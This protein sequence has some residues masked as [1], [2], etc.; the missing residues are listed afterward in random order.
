MKEAGCSEL[1]Q[2]IIDGL[3]AKVSRKVDLECH[4]PQKYRQ[5]ECKQTS[6]GSHCIDP[7]CTFCRIR[8]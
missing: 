6:I 3:P 1:K 4:A 8:F 2:I 5:E 7:E